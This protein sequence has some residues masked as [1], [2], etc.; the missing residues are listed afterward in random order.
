M[1]QID[2]RVAISRSEK[3]SLDTKS[4]L[5]LHLGQFILY[6][7]KNEKLIACLPRLNVFIVTP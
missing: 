2:A 4:K 1:L 7:G 3:I 5:V 6:A